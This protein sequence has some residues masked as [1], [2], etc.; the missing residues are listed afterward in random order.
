MPRCLTFVTLYMI[1][2]ALHQF[3]YLTIAS[4]QPTLF[5]KSQAV[6]QARTSE[7]LLSVSS[8]GLHG[9]VELAGQQLQQDG[10]AIQEE[11]GDG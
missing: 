2:Q 11:G 1:C 5:L 4:R 6:S 8:K 9:P 3:S 10:A 7:T